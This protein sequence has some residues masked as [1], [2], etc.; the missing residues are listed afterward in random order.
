M[1]VYNSDG[2]HLRKKGKEKLGDLINLNLIYY[3]SQET[4]K[5]TNRQNRIIDSGGL[6][7]IL[8]QSVNTNN[9]NICINK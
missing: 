9:T 8:T 4:I 6:G 2:L 5:W 7:K 3:V 1:G